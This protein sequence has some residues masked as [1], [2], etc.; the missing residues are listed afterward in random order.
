MWLGARGTGMEFTDFADRCP[1]GGTGN[2]EDLVG[3]EFSGFH[4]DIM[5]R[6]RM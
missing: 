6:F 5:Q 3:A 1:T 4:H 2:G